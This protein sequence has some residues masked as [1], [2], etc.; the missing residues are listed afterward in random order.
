MAGLLM[1][2][3]RLLRLLRLPGAAEPRRFRRAFVVVAAMA[4]CLFG[5]SSLFAQE[6]PR[7]LVTLHSPP[8]GV[9]RV[10]DEVVVSI[11][12]DHPRPGDVSIVFPDPPPSLVPG[13]YT[14][15]PTIVPG[16][17]G[18]NE[19]WTEGTYSF[20]L[21]A[22]GRWRLGPF[23]VSVAGIEV[24]HPALD[25]DVRPAADSAR[26]SRPLYL[27]WSIDGPVV[28]G[29][30]ST[31]ILTLI[32]AGGAADAGAPVIA[33]GEGYLMEVLPGEPG[34]EAK[35]VVARFS[36]TPLQAGRLTLPTAE[37]RLPA[38]TVLR[39]GSFSFPV[40]AS[41]G[42][43]PTDHATGIDSALPSAPGGPARPDGSGGGGAD[44]A[45]FAASTQALAEALDR[46]PSRRVA[47][48]VS[49]AAAALAA[50]D[51]ARALAALRAA[52]RLVPGGGRVRGARARLELAVAGR[53]GSDVPWYPFPL[54]G[55]WAAL[56]CVF[57]G[58]LFLICVTLRSRRGFRIVLVACVLSSAMAFWA[59]RGDPAASGAVVLRSSSARRVPEE[60]AGIVSELADGQDARITASAGDWLYVELP[61][62]PAG[63]VPRESAIRY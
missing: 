14:I 39:S 5:G 15:A 45:R 54:S 60:G 55:P 24:D 37:A 17:S 48:R 49:D 35:G 53:P 21:R 25:I 29:R 20:G 56:L 57:T 41:S 33:V 26:P 16:P 4:G 9:Y 6:A 59:I 28:A 19:T 13:R 31:A 63:W 36:V 47:A 62:G 52:E 8:G 43:G 3:L 44:T 1:A 51:P 11:L 12:V 61:S 46:F 34:D 18:A 30:P 32:G 10:G 38:G 7:V 2:P 58:L 40:V 22:E 23:A 42:G 27:R 50:G